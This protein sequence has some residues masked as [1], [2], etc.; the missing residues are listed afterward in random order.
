MGAGALR[1]PREKQQRS[2]F[3]RTVQIYSQ[4]LHDFFGRVGKTPD[5]FGQQEVFA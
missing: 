3:E 2:G 1:L 5:Q 4:M